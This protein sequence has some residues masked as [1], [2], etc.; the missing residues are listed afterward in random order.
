[1][2]VVNVIEDDDSRSS[3]PFRVSVNGLMLLNAR[4]FARRFETSFAASLAGAREVDRRKS[5][6]S[7]P[8]GTGQP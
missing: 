7:R 3:R 4:G 8:N 1:M 6:G 2:H 5:R